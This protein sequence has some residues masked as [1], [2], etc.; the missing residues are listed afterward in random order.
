MSQVLLVNASARGE[1]SHS[2]LIA[3]EFVQ[4]WQAAHAGD[5]VVERDL[6]H[7]TIPFVSEPFI[8][9][10]YTPDENRTPEQRELLAL[11]DTLVDE[12]FA[13]DVFVFG[14]P[15][16]NFSVP[17]VFKAW[18]DQI[19]RFGRTFT[20]GPNGPVGLLENKR[21]FV[22]TARGGG[23]YGPGGARE[24]AN[25]EDGYIKTVFGF[26]GVTDITFIHLENMNAA[27]DVKTPSLVAARA[28]IAE[29]VA[30]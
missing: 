20:Y 1:A 12:L 8:G 25:F 7:Q 13:A 16:Y 29:L 6:G 27:D 21:A 9:A 23:G 3:G 28:Q 15:M 2:R 24:A 18:V 22:V 5:T 30:A 19:A 11:S 10:M 26:L 14:V 4:A 17:G